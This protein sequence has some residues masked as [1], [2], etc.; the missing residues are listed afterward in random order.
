MISTLFSPSNHQFSHLILIFPCFFFHQFD[1]P[2]TYHHGCHII[3][4]HH[5]SLSFFFILFLF[6]QPSSHCHFHG[7]LS[8]D[9]D[10]FSALSI[11]NGT[12]SGIISSTNETYHIHHDRSSL[13]HLLFLSSHYKNANNFKCGKL[14]LLSIQP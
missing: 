12:L 6:L 14:T 2:F 13:K 1:S 9:P 4:S 7:S 5:F 3:R 8:G 11:F 10:S